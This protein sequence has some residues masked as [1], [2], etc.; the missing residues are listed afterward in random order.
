VGFEL[1]SEMLVL[2]AYIGSRH[3]FVLQRPLN[4]S[5]AMKFCSTGISLNWVYYT[6][7]CCVFDNYVP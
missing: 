1:S 3:K 2:S 6:I 7:S 5:E 4:F